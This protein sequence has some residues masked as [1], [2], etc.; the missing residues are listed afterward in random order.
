MKKNTAILSI[1]LLSALFLI[2]CAGNPNFTGGKNYV[3]QGVWDKAAESF[4]LA[5]AGDPKNPEIQYYLGWAYCE[6]GDYQKAG[7]AFEN[8]RGL[9][10]NF[11]DKCDSKIDEYW[12]D[13]AARGQEFAEGSQF[14]DATNL[15]E[16]ALHLKPND[17]NT[18]WYVA[19]LYGQMGDVDKAQEKFSRALE[20]DPDNDTTLTNYANFLGE[21]GREAEA[22]PL[23]E[24]L[25]SM[26]EDDENLSRHL[27]RLYD[28]AGQGDKALEIYKRLG[29]ASAIMNDAYESYDNGEFEHAANLYEK[30]MMISEK[31]SENY[32]NAYYYSAAAYYKAEN[33]EKAIEVSEGLIEEKDDDPLYFRLLGNCYKNVGRNNEALRA[34]KKSEELE[35]RK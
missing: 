22:I 23:F 30:A 16:E 10:D 27:A 6:T 25:S 15:L 33:W 24:R 8:S 31:G 7:A 35:S 17:L 4:E 12:N 11:S 19:G 18:H 28:R 3:K 1:G 9:S 5:A 29:D 13:L 14:E 32:F 2:S 21:H 20:I 34:F 26:K